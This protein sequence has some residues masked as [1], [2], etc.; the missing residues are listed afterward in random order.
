VSV[1]GIQVRTSVVII[2]RFSHPDDA[3]YT[4]VPRHQLTRLQPLLERRPPAAR[5]SRFDLMS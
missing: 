1:Y 5:S 2:S 4:T 3:F